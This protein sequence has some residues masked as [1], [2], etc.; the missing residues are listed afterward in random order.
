MG[1]IDHEFLFKLAFALQR[2]QEA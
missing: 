2:A 1:F